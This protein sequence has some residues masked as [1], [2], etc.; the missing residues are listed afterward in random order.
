[1]LTYKEDKTKPVTVN[2]TFS[3]QV[4]R[5]VCY[6]RWRSVLVRKSRNTT[7]IAMVKTIWLSTI[8]LLAI[9]EVNRVGT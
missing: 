2:L 7:E 4:D 3:S 1:M 6:F 5:F 9:C 8:S